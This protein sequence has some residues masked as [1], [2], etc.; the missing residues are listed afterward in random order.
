MSH[1]SPPLR[2]CYIGSPALALCISDGEAVAC[3]GKTV[4]SFNRI[5]SRHHDESIT[6]ARD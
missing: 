2:E 5:R 6:P 3:D 4:A 1:T